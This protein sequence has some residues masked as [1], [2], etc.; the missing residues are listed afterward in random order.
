[1]ADEPA[2]QPGGFVKGT[3]AIVLPHETGF[4]RRCDGNSDNFSQGKRFKQ[5]ARAAEC[6]EDEGRWNERLK[7]V[8]KQKPVE[9]PKSGA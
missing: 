3:I 6:D 8:A 7:K 5:A 9:K 1:M 2:I 4:K